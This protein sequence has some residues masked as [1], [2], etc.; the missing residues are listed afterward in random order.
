MRDALIS[1]LVWL[2]A[3]PAALELDP[4][5]AAAAVAA[6]R[7]SLAVEAPDCGGTGVI[8]HGDGHRTP[9]P[10]PNTCPCKRSKK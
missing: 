5:R 1:F 3:E 2:S 4:P 8:V 6:A 10:C 9:C 7:S